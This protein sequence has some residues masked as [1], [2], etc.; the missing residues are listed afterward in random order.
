MRE[1]TT[2]KRLTITFEGRAVEGRGIPLDCLTGTL[3]GIQ[4]TLRLLAE[5][6]GGS[7]GSATGARCRIRA[8]TALRIVRVEPGS[9]VFETEVGRGGW[10]PLEP[11]PIQRALDSLL[12]QET[13]S[14]LPLGVK[15]RL[16]RVRRGLPSDLRVFLGDA[17]GELRRVEIKPASA[18]R[19]APGPAEEVVLHGWL[20]EVNW[21]R[22]TAQL[23]RDPGP[24]VEL[25]FREVLDERMRGLAN[26][27][28]EVTGTGRL[29]RAAQGA[30]DERWGPVRVTEITATHG[31]EPFDLEGFLAD[32]DP[33]RFDPDRLVTARL[34]EDEWISFQSAIRDGRKT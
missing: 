33:P 12:G 16:L 4:E 27:H 18:R 30:E 7:E 2:T 26:R 20:R 15:D 6:F 28:V 13:D 29:R 17:E 14:G 21:K 34:T 8:Q 5:H 25:R 32:P 23:H 1:G 9:L 3:T 10:L 11:S 19:P 31:S 22:K 24:F